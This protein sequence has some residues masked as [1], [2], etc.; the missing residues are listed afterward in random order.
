MSL[1]SYTELKKTVGGKSRAD[2]PSV[3]DKWA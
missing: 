1:L 3:S 2:V